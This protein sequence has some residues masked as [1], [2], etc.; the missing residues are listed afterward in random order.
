MRRLYFNFSSY[1]NKYTDKSGKIIDIDNTKFKELDQLIIRSTNSSPYSY[2]TIV[3]IIFYSNFPAS[4]RITK[5]SYRLKSTSFYL[6]G[7]LRECYTSSTNWNVIEYYWYGEKAIDKEQW[8]DP[9]WR[10][11]IEIKSFL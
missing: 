10:K 3:P 9:D 11:K 4:Q 1:Y 7:I 5:H 8:L 2:S 6:H